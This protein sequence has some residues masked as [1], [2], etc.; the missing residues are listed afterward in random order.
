MLNKF[1]VL[2]SFYI[3]IGLVQP[4]EEKNLQNKVT[5]VTGAVQGIGYAIANHFLKAGVKLVVILDKQLEKG[6]VAAKK[7]NNKYGEDKAIFIYCDVTKD[8]EKCYFLLLERY[9]YI[10]VLVNN[11]GVVDEYCPEITI[12]TNSLAVIEWSL[13]FW[14]HMRKDRNGRGGTIINLSSMFGHMVHPFLSVYTASKYAVLG[15]SKSLGH[16]YTYR[17]TSV[18]VL[19]LCPGFTD[20]AMTRQPMVIPEQLEDFNKLRNAS[21]WQKADDV[22]RGAVQVFESAESGT[23]WDIIGGNAPSEAPVSVTLTAEYID[24]LP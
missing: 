19:T 14:Q 1:I 24:S 22:G 10:D 4:N 20:T 15:F 12:D 16:E 6:M 5:V 23:A 21:Q 9:K 18:R 3:V 8:L 17:N 7:L 11:A 13:K 2:C